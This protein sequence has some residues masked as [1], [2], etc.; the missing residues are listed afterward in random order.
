MGKV[1]SGGRQADLYRQYIEG[2]TLT[3]VYGGSCGLK[4]C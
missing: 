4:T 3:R 1:A 2:S